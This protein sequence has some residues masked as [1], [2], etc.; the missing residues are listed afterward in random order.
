VLK[1]LL[2]EDGWN[3]YIVRVNGNHH[4]TYINGVKTCEYTETDA[5]IPS[6]GIIAIQLHSGGVAKIEFRHVTITEL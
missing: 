5:S 3:S 6:K 1:L 4:I 2:N